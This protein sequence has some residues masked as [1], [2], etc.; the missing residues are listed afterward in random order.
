[1][2]G[3]PSAEEVRTGQARGKLIFRLA[4]DEKHPLAT[5]AVNRW[6]KSRGVEVFYGKGLPSVLGDT[7]PVNSIGWKEH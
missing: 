2:R 5:M 1:M 7:P 3:I 6:K 4:V